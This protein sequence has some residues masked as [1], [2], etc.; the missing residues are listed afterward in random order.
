MPRQ[1]GASLGHAK[2]RLEVPIGK[3][4]KF[5]KIRLSQIMNGENEKVAR[6][7]VFLLYSNFTL[8]AYKTLVYILKPTLHFIF[9]QTGYS[10]TLVGEITTQKLHVGI[11]LMLAIV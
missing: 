4:I 5:S 10:L 11:I 1:K 9:D 7:N 2:P 8:I 6:Q 3:S